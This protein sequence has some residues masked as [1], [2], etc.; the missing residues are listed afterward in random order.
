MGEAK[1]RVEKKKELWGETLK[2]D[3]KFSSAKSFPSFT[4][5]GRNNNLNAVKAYH[6]LMRLI[7][8]R[9][10]HLHKTLLKMIEEDNSYS[11]FVL[12]K[13]YWETVAML[14]YVYISARNYIKNKKYKELLDW[15]I[16]HALGGKKFPPDDL[17]QAEG[18]TREDFLQTNLLTWMRKMDKDFDK[19]VGKGKKLSKFKEVYDDFIAEAGHSTFLGL[20]ICE[21]KLADGSVIPIIDR[22]YQTND[23]LTTLNHTSLASHY[24]FHY[25]KRFTEEVEKQ[26]KAVE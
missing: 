19:V 8:L 7:F 26:I 25:W 2:M 20:Y 9:A 22:T 3:E 11:S 12:L 14:G 23:D 5:G 15:T 1:R 21:E 4:L 18:R 10:K 16:K 13:A 24:L 6:H 17:V